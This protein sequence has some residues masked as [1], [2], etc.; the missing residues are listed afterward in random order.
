MLFKESI[1]I[2]DADY[3]FETGKWAKQANGSV[4]LKWKN[5]VLLGN[6]TANKSAKEDTD[7]FPLTVDYREKFYSRGQFAGG[8]FKREGRPTNL[9]ILTSRLTDRP[10]RPLFP[11]SFMNEVQIFITLLSA[12]EDQTS[13]VHSITCASAALMASNIPFDGPVAGVRVGRIAEKFILFPTQS[14]QKISD[15]NLLLAGTSRAVTMVEGSAN[16]LSKEVMLDAVKFGHEEIKKICALQE[17][18]RDT[19]KKPFL[20]V[21][22]VEENESLKKEIHE[23]A[24]EK[25]LK[26]NESGDK[27]LRQENIDSLCEEVLS[28]L[29]EKYNKEEIDEKQIKKDIKEA[30][31]FLEEMEV[32]IVRSQIFNKSI[33]ADGRKLDEVRSIDIEFE[34][35]PSTHGSALFTR[36]ET[37]SL[38]VVTLGTE[39]NAQIIDNVDGDYKEYFYLH[40]NFL[41][42]SV[43]EV[44]RY[45]GP[46]RREIG[47]G[48]LAENALR[49][50]IPSVDDFPYVIR[51]VSEIL[52]SNGSSSMATVC[53]ACIA[54]MEAGVPIQNA[55]AGIAMG[56][57]TDENGKYAILSDIAGLEDHFGDMDFKVAA[58]NEGITAFQL[59]TKVQGISYEIMEKALEQAEKGIL[60]ILDKMNEKIDKPREKISKLAPG[61]ITFKI[62]KSNIG[63]L[64]GPGGSNIRS[65]IEKTNAEVIV[66]DDGTVNVYG[67]EQSFAEE[68]QEIIKLQFKEAK[69]DEIYEGKVQKITE[70]GAFVEILPGKSGLC[71]ISKVSDEHVRDLEDILKVG[72]TV[73]VKVVAIDRQGRLNLSIK[74]AVE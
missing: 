51:V 70:Y 32:D 2:L 47:H 37:Q 19:V 43:G 41:P 27:K 20:N 42:Y 61:V 17:K 45:M 11:K 24:H 46:G 21:P 36:G 5:I 52:E 25:M 8:F 44:R 34:V 63:E 72:Q 65:I 35:L 59:D 50:V 48:K 55:V 54:L 74:D 30:S 56:L 13:Q 23:M 16:Q 6:A 40:Y 10:I 12:D 53:S 15:L 49:P 26:A 68:A 67:K 7:F 71:H 66:K 38:G 57:I 73:K 18:L 58:T 69:V 9:E 62:D 60:H 22:E 33:R 3:S 31:I 28:T 4:V 1:K 39:N 29:E 64:I 14:E